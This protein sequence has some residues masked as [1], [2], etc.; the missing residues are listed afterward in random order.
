MLP[1]P[2]HRDSALQIFQTSSDISTPE[3]L[4]AVIANES[5]ARYKDIPEKERKIWIGSQIYALC[6]ILHYQAPS[7]IDVSVDAEFADKMIMEDEGL[8]C[9]RQVEMQEAFRKGIGK[10][11]GEFYGITPTS[12]LQFLKGYRNGEKRAKAMSI[13]YAEEQKKLKDGDKLFWETVEWAKQHGYEIPEFKHT[14]L[15]DDNQH[16][17]RIARQREEILR[18]INQ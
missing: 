18:N 2:T 10:D 12:L 9:L 1:A 7:A 3:K 13:L 15:E 14:P 6:M 11:Y 4:A 16:A 8:R 5:V 17:Q